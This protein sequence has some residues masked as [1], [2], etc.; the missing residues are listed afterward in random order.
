MPPAVGTGG[1]QSVQD[2]FFAQ[3]TIGAVAFLLLL[4]TVYLYRTKESGRE[5]LID[6]YEAALKAQSERNHKLIEAKDAVIHK[7]QE[8]RM[9][10]MKA[11]MNQIAASN[12]AMEQAAAG[13]EAALD[14]ITKTGGTR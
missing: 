8:D 2:I 5:K 3:G 9:A 7:L 10:E 14:A 6:Q 13:F 1:A 4:A 11:G 12:A